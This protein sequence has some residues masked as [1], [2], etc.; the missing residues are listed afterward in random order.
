M[1]TTHLEKRYNRYEVNS[2][3]DYFKNDL[4][5]LTTIELCITEMCTR[6][7]GFCPRSDETVYKNNPFH[8]S[9]STVNEFCKKCK[10]ENFGGDI[11]ISGFG[12][13]FL[14][15]NIFNIVSLIKFNLPDN[16]V[17][18]TNNGDCLTSEK[19]KEIFYCGLD[20]MIISC[21]D[22]YDAKNKFIQMFKDTNISNQ[23]FEIR[24]LWYNEGENE[25]EFAK[26]N[27]FNNR[28]GTSTK[29]NGLDV[30]TGECYLPFYKLVIDWNGE[31]LLC[32]NDWHR[33]HKGF[34][35]IN[36][37]SLSEIWYGDE[38]TKVR[39][40]LSIGNRIGPSCKN[41]SIDGTIIGK[42]SVKTL[43]F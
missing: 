14:N 16:R 17:C 24:E 20:Y 41:C 4:K 35:N 5:G 13:P 22:G 28:S 33:R 12:E 6:K 29:L 26:R 2:K 7:C 15:K 8:M 32:C 1:T 9:L 25:L 42:E 23:K 40:D 31:I 27:K 19:I 21:Y 18:I 30:K 43:G 11:H 10:N 39:K 3:K 34:G 36:K 37:N 38:F